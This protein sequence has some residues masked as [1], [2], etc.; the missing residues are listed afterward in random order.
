MNFC[1]YPKHEFACPQ[2]MQCPHLGGAALGEVVHVA[3]DSDDTIDLLYRQLD[4]ARQSVS[5]LVAENETLKREIERLKL[6]LKLERQNK[7]ATNRQRQSD[8]ALAKTSESTSETQPRKRGA[9]VGHPG[10][11]RPTPTEYD[12]LVEV[13]VP[14]N[15]PHCGGPV[16]VY[17]SQEPVDHLQEDLIDGR[18]HVTLF[19]HPEARCRSCRRWVQN[20]GEGEIL[21]SM[22]GPRLR[23]IAV[24]LH[25]DIGISLRKV[26]RAIADLFE[27]RFTPAALIGFEKLM[28]AN[29]EPVSDDIRKKVAASDGAVHADETYWILNGERAYYWIH[30]TDQYIHFQFDTSRAGEVSR[31]LLGVDFAGTLVTDCYSAYDAQGAKAK[32]KCLSHL[33]RTARDWQKLTS[34][35]SA[36]YRFFESIREWVKRGCDF[37][38]GRDCLSKGHQANEKAWLRAE[39]KRLQD[40]PL[41]HEKAVTLQERINRYAG[42]W[43]VFLDDPRVPPTNNHAERSLRPLV[44]MRK[45]TFGHRSHSGATRMARLITIQETAKRHGRRALEVYYRLAM[46]AGK[47]PNALLRYIYG[48]PGMTG[49]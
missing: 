49:S 17:T 13:A 28:A 23:A 3:N 44:I 41:S 11:Y 18:R 35:D 2:L 8:V 42:C 36:D 4:A 30:A 39:L 12:A 25:N 29:A 47:F 48:G 9:P 1:F 43:L 7:F 46:L 32:Q 16:S 38:R 33:A 14:A 37:H 20:A 22:I 19:R 31:D 15:C 5:D 10:W 45:I 40:C 24:Y 26:P 34:A 21:G 27:F 6:E